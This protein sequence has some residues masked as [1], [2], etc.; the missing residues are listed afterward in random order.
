MK[1][2]RKFRLTVFI[3]SA[4]CALSIAYNVASEYVLPDIEGYFQRK[5]YYERVISQK[6]LS[7]HRAD[8]W[9]EEVPD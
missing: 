5:L 2:E 1:D 7:L 3:A 9:R 4:L 8:Y 6:G